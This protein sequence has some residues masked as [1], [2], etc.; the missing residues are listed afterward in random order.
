MNAQG[1]SVPENLKATSE[2]QKPSVPETPGDHMST[3]DAHSVHMHL[4]KSEV[5]D[6]PSKDGRMNA[7]IGV[8]IVSQHPI[9]RAG[10]VRLLDG[11][12]GLEIV[13]EASDVADAVALAEGRRPD[14]VILDIDASL[15]GVANTIGRILAVNA[16]L[17]ILFV[18]GAQDPATVAEAIAS[19]ARRVVSREAET[20]AL[21]QMIRAV[22]SDSEAGPAP[23]FQRQPTGAGRPPLARADEAKMASLTPQEHNV[24]SL[25]VAGLA[26]KSIAKRLSISERTVRNHMTA[27]L[28]KL[29]L[30]NRVELVLYAYQHHLAPGLDA[31]RADDRP[32]KR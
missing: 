17:R 24:M 12:P 22:A 31:S 1:R 5:S 10:F 21:L 14:L 20:G 15:E 32:P 18:S 9:V 2:V 7:A 3:K 30:T 8:L 13:G 4:V 16:G 25:V 29:N 26:N 6:H 23:E 27:I 19:G 28:Q 11:Q